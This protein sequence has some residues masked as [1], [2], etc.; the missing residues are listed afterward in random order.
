MRKSPISPNIYHELHHAYEQKATKKK[1]KRRENLIE[2]MDSIF[3]ATDI[4]RCAHA[5]FIGLI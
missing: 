2:K 3:S 1:G 5:V 4:L